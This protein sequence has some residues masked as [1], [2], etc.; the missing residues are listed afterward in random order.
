MCPYSVTRVMW[1][2]GMSNKQTAV[3]VVSASQQN[4]KEADL[5]LS[6]APKYQWIGG[7]GGQQNLKYRFW[8]EGMCVQ[9]SV[10]RETWYFPGTERRSER[11]QQWIKC[12]LMRLEAMHMPEQEVS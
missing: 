2:M 4:L 7:R 8:V 9:S 6:W 5:E 11:V 1:E 3:A 12:G 10:V